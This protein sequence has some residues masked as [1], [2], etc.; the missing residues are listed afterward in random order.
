MACESRHAGPPMFRRF[1]RRKP[2]AFQR[3]AAILNRRA[4]RGV[5]PQ[6]RPAA[7][8]WSASVPKYNTQRPRSVQA[9]LAL[10]HVCETLEGMTPTFDNARMVH[11]ASSAAL[12]LSGAS[13]INEYPMPYTARRP[14]RGRIDIYA[15]VGKFRVAIEI[16]ARKPRIGSLIKL[17]NFDGLRIVA[18]RGVSGDC[19]NGIDAVVSIPVKMLP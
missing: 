13:V 7:N 9:H 8:A 18:M 4:R 15:E 16:D 5:L 1:F 2:L 10:K 14:R 3:E 19:P 11:T 12:R 6:S 17:N